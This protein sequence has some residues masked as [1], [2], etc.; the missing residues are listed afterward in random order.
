MWSGAYVMSICPFLGLWPDGRTGGLAEVMGQKTEGR[1][2]KR[3]AAG[4]G[5]WSRGLRTLRGYSERN[6]V[7]AMFQE[8]VWW[9]V[10]GGRDRTLSQVLLVGG[11]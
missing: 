4:T 2:G 7:T 8:C 1:P 5:Q 11:S 6:K 10:W 9:F 3:E